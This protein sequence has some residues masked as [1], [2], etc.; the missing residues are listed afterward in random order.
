M[1]FKKIHEACTAQGGCV[2][3][4][5]MYLNVLFNY[6]CPSC[7]NL[8]RLHWTHTE[9]RYFTHIL[10][11]VNLAT[12]TN[13]EYII[14]ASTSGSARPPTP[15]STAVQE[16]LQRDNSTLGFP[17]A[18]RFMCVMCNHEYHGLK[19]CPLCQSTMYTTEVKNRDTKQ[20]ITSTVCKV[21]GS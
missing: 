19:M 6:L 5:D 7:G 18:E 16:T 17:V 21:K 4:T 12:L 8:L 14:P 20:D 13:C 3:A 11:N 10:E 1:Q 9:G 2:K 15:F